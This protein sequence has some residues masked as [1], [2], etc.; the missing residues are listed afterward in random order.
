MFMDKLA[1][2]CGGDEQEG[3]RSTENPGSGSPFQTLPR[4]DFLNLAWRR[5]KTPADDPAKTDMNLHSPPA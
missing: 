4:R 3:D 2:F 5:S 1:M